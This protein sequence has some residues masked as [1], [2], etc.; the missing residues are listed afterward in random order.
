MLEIIVVA[1]LLAAERAFAEWRNA[2]ERRYLINAAIATTPAELKQ[3]EAKPER[4]PRPQHEPIDGF[5]EA[6]GI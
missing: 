6:V 1:V 3:L 2:K 5:S 4:R